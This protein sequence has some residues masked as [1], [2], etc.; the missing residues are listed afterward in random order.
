MSFDINQRLLEAASRLTSNHFESS[1]EIGH[2]T[3]IFTIIATRRQ[4]VATTNS[5]LVV[6][7]IPLV[8]R[9]LIKS[10]KITTSRRRQHHDLFMKSSW[11]TH[12]ALSDKYEPQ[13]IARHKIARALD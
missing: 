3:D 6:G 13:S 9:D 2:H 12:S 5:R 8:R 7:S 11:P 1:I 10:T 4:P